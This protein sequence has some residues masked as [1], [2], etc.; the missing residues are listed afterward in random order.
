MQTGRKHQFSERIFQWKVVICCQRHLYSFTNYIKCRVL[1]LVALYPHSQCKWRLIRYYPFCLF[2]VAWSGFKG[3]L[4]AKDSA[5]DL[6]QADLCLSTLSWCMALCK[7][8]S[9]VLS[10]LL[11]WNVKSFGCSCVYQIQDTVCSAD[12]FLF[13]IIWGRGSQRNKRGNNMQNRIFW[14]LKSETVRSASEHPLIPYLDS[15]LEVGKLWVEMDGSKW[16]ALFSWRGLGMSVESGDGSSA[17]AE[18]P[19]PNSPCLRLQACLNASQLTG[20]QVWMG[21]IPSSPTLLWYWMRM[22]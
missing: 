16:G 7:W 8:L 2:I 17:I 13:M 3:P 18:P 22:A 12:M 20:A 9:E 5:V 10:L 15:L 21:Q 4:W 6:R 19:T 11:L 1:G 14:K